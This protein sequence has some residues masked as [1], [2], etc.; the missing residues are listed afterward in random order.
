MISLIYS[1]SIPCRYIDCVST[2]D[3]KIEVE[4]SRTKGTNGNAGEENME[5]NRRGKVYNV[6]YIQM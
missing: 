5:G 4:A 1:S 3:T 2:S 6:C